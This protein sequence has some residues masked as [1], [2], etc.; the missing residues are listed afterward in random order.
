MRVLQ[1]RTSHVS[2]THP[3]RGQD[4]GQHRA[5]SYQAPGSNGTHWVERVPTMLPL[6][7]PRPQSLPKRGVSRT[8]KGSFSP[9]KWA[10]QALSAARTYR[11]AF[12]DLAS[13]PRASRKHRRKGY[14]RCTVSANKV[15]SA[16]RDGPL[17]GSHRSPGITG[18]TRPQTCRGSGK[19]PGNRFGFGVAADRS[20]DGRHRAGDHHRANADER[21]ARDHRQLALH[22]GDRRIGAEAA[23]E[24]SLRQHPHRLVRRVN[25]RRASARD[26]GCPLQQSRDAPLAVNGANSDLRDT[27]LDANACHDKWRGLALPEYLELPRYAGHRSRRDANDRGAIPERVI[28]R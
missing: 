24:L 18:D 22:G 1:A 4:E 6:R 8:P 27:E 11:P 21:H 20:R 16:F 10:R 2:Q 3:E 7:H 15:P 5:R 19:I 25:Q 14:C 28:Q 23:L 12:A 13:A 9:R 26:S 17:R